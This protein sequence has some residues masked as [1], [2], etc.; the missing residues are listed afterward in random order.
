MHVIRAQQVFD[1]GRFLGAGDVVLDGRSIVSVNAPTE[2][3]GDVVVEDLGDVT[4]L[5]G[6]VDA[7]QHVTWDC[8]FD[9]VGWH[10]QHDDAAL[11]ERARANARQAL[12]AG[13]TTVRDLGGRGRAPFDLREDCSR[14]PTAGPT[15]LVAGPAL[16]TPGGH[17]WF[18]G[19]QC[20]GS[21]DLVAAVARLD[22]AGVDVIKV[23]ATGGNLTPGS[24][25]HESQFGPDELRAVVEAAHAAGLP[26]AAHAHGTQ[27]VSDALDARVDTIEHCS[28]MTADGVAE[29]PTLVGRLA[30]SGITVS[31]TGGSIPGPLPPA[32]AVR[33]PA[34]NAH[35]RRLLEA[36]VRCIIATDAGIGPAKPHDVLARTV[37]HAVEDLGATVEGALAMCTAGAAD[38]IGL[39]DRA[40]RLRP[41]VP[42]DL[43]V[44]SGRVDRDPSAM[45]NPVRVLRGGVTV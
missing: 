26:V 21:D 23:M 17:C 34:L 14:N 11:L 44:V 33:M 2:Y 16:T 3:A 24:D 39:G 4:V 42:A 15:L 32:I 7:H 12:A 29:D 22:E 30:S 37:E 1:G 25:P 27:G 8:S 41:G 31:I 20:Q 35:G 6:L 36:G 38:A 45:R 18:L 43:L 13:V 10:E 40:G 9:A 5:P 28:F 19:G